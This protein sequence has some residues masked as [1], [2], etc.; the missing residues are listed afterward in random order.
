MDKSAENPPPWWCDYFVVSYNSDG[1]FRVQEV[2]LPKWYGSY[3]AGDTPC[4]FRGCTDS[5]ATNYDQKA[6]FDDRTCTYA[7]SSRRALG[8]GNESSAHNRRLDHFG[9]TVVTVNGCLDP[10]AM[11]YDSVATDHVTSVCKYSILGCTDS[12][13]ANFQLDFT[14]DDG[15][16]T[17]EPTGCPS[18]SASNYDSIAVRSDGSCVYVIPGCTDSRAE[19]YVATANTPTT[20]SFPTYGCNLPAALNYDSTVDRM[21]EGACSMERQGCL[22]SLATNFDSTANTQVNT[23]ADGGCDYAIYGCMTATGTQNYDSV[24]TATTDTSCRWTVFGCTDVAYSD[25]NPTA[26]AMQGGGC[27]GQVL[28]IGCTIGSAENYD[29]TA[30]SNSGCRFLTTGCTDSQVPPLSKPY[31]VAV[32]CRG[33]DLS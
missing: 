23:A 19:N 17:F 28:V 3:C 31:L 22:D 32:P 16:C 30:N 5:T 10:A 20:C 11:N 33:C 15:S 24:A 7:T 4:Q 25:F 9:K 26:T 13:G 21:Q 12:R 1:Q 8:D 14:H 29:S 18:P 6:T 27:T 2:E